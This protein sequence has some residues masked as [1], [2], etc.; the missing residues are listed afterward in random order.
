MPP[1]K[2][3]PM[4]MVILG[5][6]ESGLVVAGPYRVRLPHVWQAGAELVSVWQAGAELVQVE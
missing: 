5:G 4:L 3:L 2:L 6:Q 1:R